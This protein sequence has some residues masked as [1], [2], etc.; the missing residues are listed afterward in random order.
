MAERVWTRGVVAG[1]FVLHVAVGGCTVDENKYKFGTAGAD[2]PASSGQPGS[3]GSSGQGGSGANSGSSGTVRATGGGGATGSASGGRTGVGEGGGDGSDAG[4][5]GDTGGDTGTGTGGAGPGIT[6]PMGQHVCADRCVPDDDVNSCGT[7]C[8]PCTAPS[9][10]IATCDGTKCGADCSASGKKL[11]LG[12]CIPM[13]E[14]CSGTCPTGTHEC[15]GICPSSQD[16]NACGTACTPCPVPVGATQ[17]T[18]DGTA[19]GFQ[20]SPGYHPCGNGCATADDAKAC[21]AACTV[22]PTSANGTAVCLG[23]SCNIECKSGYH[24]CGGQCASDASPLTCGDSCD[25]CEVPIGGTATCVSGKCDSHCPTGQVKCYGKCIPSGM[26]CEGTCPMGSHNCNDNCVADTSTTACGEAC[27]QCTKPTGGSAVSCTAGA[28]D[29]TCGSGYHRCSGACKTDAD[30][31][32]CGATCAKCP[33]TANGSAICQAASCDIRCNTDYHLC[34]G[35]CIANSSTTQCGPT[36][37]PCTAPT[38][39]TVTCNGTSCVPACPGTQKICGGACVA[40]ND[41][42]GG[43]CPGASHNCNG[44][45]MPNKDVATCGTLC[46]PCPAPP[47]NG[48]AICTTA[49]VCDIMCANGFHKCGSTCVPNDS[50]DS[51]GSMCTPCTPPANATPGC[52]AQGACTFTCNKG[53]TG[54]NCQFPRFQAVPL[55]SGYPRNQVRDISGDGAFVSGVLDNDA[56]FRGFRWTLTSATVSPFALGPATVPNAL[57]NDGAYMAGLH[58][59]N[60]VSSAARW[61]S[62]FTA[63]LLVTST[64]DY[65]EAFDISSDGS[66]AVGYHNS[67]ALLWRPINGTWNDITSTSFTSLSLTGVSGDGSKAAG[68]G[69]TTAGAMQPV[70]W[71]SSTGA[72]VQLSGTAGRARG[73]SR[74]GKVIVGYTNDTIPTRWSGTNFA[75][76]EMLAT[77]PAA[78]TET[79]GFIVATNQDGSVSVGFS[80]IGSGSDEAV[81]WTSSGIQKISDIL[82]AEGVNLAGWSL[83]SAVAVSNDGK[84]VAGTGDYNALQRGWVARLP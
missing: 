10:G 84:T 5:G 47:S 63:T 45:C 57:S 49:G 21:G 33:T 66:I 16:V 13:N 65:A 9:D 55:P 27:Q 76:R 83:G 19:C 82:S 81:I 79:G 15:G 52:S 32:A 28:C 3:S 37:S 60:G 26:A 31:T 48:S 36:C 40:A 73:I 14:A 38:G 68:Y 6:C 71:S 80:Y 35:K 20:C 17:A 69:D 67:A 58:V 8:S 46:T 62:S 75:T 7:S 50:V 30:V 53:Y 74:D 1:L 42:C 25:P 23:G 43:A 22:C 24:P 77:L 2:S 56:E 72:V 34:D 70:W 59:L 18:C 51:C 12:A 54:A 78:G 11:C 29:F 41:A 61:N 44:L 64:D 4:A 39:G